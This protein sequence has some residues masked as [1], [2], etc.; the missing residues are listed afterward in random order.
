MRLVPA[1]LLTMVL[2]LTAT[3]CLP[4]PGSPPDT[5]NGAPIA[6]RQGE[7]VGTADPDDLDRLGVSLDRVEVHEDGELVG[8]FEV[9]GFV[10]LEEAAE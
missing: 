5:T 8:Y 3:G 6:N 4:T 9:G 10:P 2:T 1:A 7:I